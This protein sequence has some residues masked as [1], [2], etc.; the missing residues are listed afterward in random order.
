MSRRRQDRAQ[1]GSFRAPLQPRTEAQRSLIRAIT[2]CEQVI[3]IGPAGTGKT[4]VPAVMAADLLSSH[5]IRRIVLT[6]PNVEAGRPIGFRPGTMEEKMAEWFAEILRVLSDRLG[7]G[8]VEGML[9]SKI[10]LVPFETMRGRTFD[11][12]FVI[13]DEAQNTTASEMLMFLTRI[14]ENSRVVVNG[15]LEQSDLRG[16]SGLATVVRMVRNQELPVQ[17][18]EFTEADI[19]RSGWVRMWI[20]AFRKAEHGAISLHLHRAG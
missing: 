4:Y 7:R 17:I 14:G 18:I 19:V 9:G 5:L 6:R 3:T 2:T 12:A 16:T 1:T 20:E 10:E 8:Q 13:L 11:D 15:D